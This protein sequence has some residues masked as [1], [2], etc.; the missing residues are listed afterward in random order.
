MTE[1]EASSNKEDDETH[2]NAAEKTSKADVPAAVTWNIPAL[3]LSV[4]QNDPSAA[5]RSVSETATRGASPLDEDQDPDVMRTGNAPKQSD[6][7]SD[8]SE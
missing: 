6:S 1:Q 5:K 8:S 7:S 4:F 2:Q 3:D